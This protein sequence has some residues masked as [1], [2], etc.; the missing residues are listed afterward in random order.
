MRI[1]GGERVCHVMPVIGL[2][3]DS[4]RFAYSF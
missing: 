3:R 2:P 1:S 4:A